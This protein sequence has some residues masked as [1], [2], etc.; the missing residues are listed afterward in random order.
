MRN[1]R[2]IIALVIAAFAVI[3]YFGRTSVNPITGEPEFFSTHPAPENRGAW[4]QDEIRKRFPDGVPA[5][6]KR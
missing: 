4:I 2:W 5:G 1:A 6:L 3:T